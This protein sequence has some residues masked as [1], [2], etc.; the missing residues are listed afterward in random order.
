MYILLAELFLVPKS[1]QMWKSQLGVMFQMMIC[2][3]HLKVDQHVNK[4]DRYLLQRGML[5]WTKL[6][7][8]I[9]KISSS[10]SDKSM[11]IQQ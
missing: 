3:D 9:L 11:T 8:R 5:K 10:S 4:E 1:L 7:Y 2:S 6:P